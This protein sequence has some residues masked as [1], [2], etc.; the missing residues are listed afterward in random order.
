MAGIYDDFRDAFSKPNNGLVQLILINIVVFLCLIL[1]QVILTLSGNRAIYDTILNQLTIPASLVK[2]VFKPWTLITYF[3]THENPFHILFNMLFL[4]WFGTLV[5]EYIGSRSL[6][7]LY[8]LGGIVG[9]LTYIGLYNLIPYFSKD[10]ASSWM[11]G[12]SGAVFAVV[13]GAAT[14][15]PHYTFILLFFGPIRIIYIAF[16]YLILSWIQLVGPNAGGNMAHVSG[17]LIGFIYIRF[18]KKGIDLGGPIDTVLNFFKKFFSPPPRRTSMR[19]TYR[20]QSKT[21][22]NYTSEND[23]PDEEEVDAIL[24]KISKSG[25]E[26]LTREEKQK[27]FKASQKK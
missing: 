11:L 12:A 10:I 13:F 21:T 2:L 14:L 8:I 3:F 16:F 9:G 25:Y 19:V 7:N 5:Q 1:L 24:D 17:A 6:I 4:Y 15:L 20:S 26:S 23:F 22:Y 18:R 27:L